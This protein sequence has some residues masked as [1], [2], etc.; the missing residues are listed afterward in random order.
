[1]QRDLGSQARLKSAEV[2]GPSAIE[3]EDMPQLLI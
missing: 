3:A 2:M 1:M